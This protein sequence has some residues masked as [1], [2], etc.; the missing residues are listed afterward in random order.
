[1]A[2][3]IRGERYSE[4]NKKKDVRES[5]ILAAKAVADCV[6][7]SLGPRGMDKMLEAPN[8]EVTITNDG[9]TILNKMDVVHPAA[10]MLVDLSKSQDIEA[11]DGTTTVVVIAGA[12]LGAAH[13]MLKQGIHPTA[14]SESFKK[15][16]DKATEV[17]EGMSSDVDITDRD[18]LLKNAMTSLNSKVVSQYSSLLAPIAVDSVLRIIDPKHDDN[19][20]LRNIKIVKKLGGTI[21]DTEMVDGLLFDQKAS[22]AAGGPTR[23]EKA[24]IALIQFCISPPKTDI[25]NSVVVHNHEAMDRVIREERNYIVKIVKK[26]KASGCN[27]LLIQKSILRDAITDLGRHFL[28]KQKILVVT[29]IERPEIE[30]VSKTLGCTPIASLDAFTPEKLGKA[31]LVEEISTS[32]GRIVKVTGV[33]NPGRTVS[34]LCRGSNQLVLD[35]ADRSIHDALCVIRCLVKKRKTICGGSAPECEVSKR[36]SDYAHTLHG[37]ESYCVR[38]YAEALEVVPYTLAENAGL[39][40]MAIVTELRNKHAAPGGANFGINVRKASITDMTD[41]NVIQPLLVSLSALT[42]A[43]ETVRLILKIDDIVPVR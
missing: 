14:V 31:E 21:D 43:T 5:N 11:G 8:G 30:F 35:E 23:I 33:T 4:E 19:V 41:E 26:I 2:A 17:L 6:R 38:A 1:M 15:A 24:K 29:N 39:H 3:Q 7:T 25:E 20:D 40:P 36:L 13:Q 10:K 9:A 42:L 18:S 28:A 12:L 27:V 16:L 22:R 34:I 32:G 37:V